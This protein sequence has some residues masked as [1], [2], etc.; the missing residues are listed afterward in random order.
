MF[1]K[2]KTPVPVYVINGFLD[3]GKSS[4]FAYTIGQPYFQTKGKTLL[5]LCEE[6]EVEY[7]EALLKQTNT[8]V[9]T[10]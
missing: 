6:G 9:E 10:I 1:G 2:E 4:F 7:S 8:V 5:I 3:S